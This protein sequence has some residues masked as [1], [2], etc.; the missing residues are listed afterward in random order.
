MI[1]R[2]TLEM[3][4]TVSYPALV[5]ADKVEPGSAKEDKGRA[6]SR[7]C[8][9]PVASRRSEWCPWTGYES[10]TKIINIGGRQ[11]N[12]G[13]FKLCCQFPMAHPRQR[14]RQV[15]S[16]QAPGHIYCGIVVIDVDS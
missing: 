3:S 9:H 5:R 1:S 6:I 12:P 15:A 10:T 7:S 16:T 11:T 2:V 8:G 14:F 4:S 13:L